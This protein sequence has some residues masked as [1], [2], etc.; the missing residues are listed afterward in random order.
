MESLGFGLGFAAFTYF[1]IIPLLH[2]LVVI[3]VAVLFLQILAYIF[4]CRR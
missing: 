1:V 4:N 2:F 3:G